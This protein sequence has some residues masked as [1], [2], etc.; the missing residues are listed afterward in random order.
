M[1]TNKE[2]LE[3]IH[4]QETALDA[5]GVSLNEERQKW[6]TLY[7]WLQE[8]NWLHRETAQTV[9]MKMREL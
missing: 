1:A 9:M 3:K 2:L 5:L 4:L 7:K 6:L 8:S